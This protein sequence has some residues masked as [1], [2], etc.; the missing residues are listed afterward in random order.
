ME[1]IIVFRDSSQE[2]YQAVIHMYSSNTYLRDGRIIQLCSPE[3]I[4]AAVTTESPKFW[5]AKIA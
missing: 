5:H 3:M 2:T 1:D 4:Y